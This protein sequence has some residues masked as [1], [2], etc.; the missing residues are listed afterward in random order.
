MNEAIRYVLDQAGWKAGDANIAFQPCD[1]STAQAAKWDPAKCT[2]TPAYSQNPSLVGVI[3][4]FNSGCAQLI[5]PG[6]I[7]LPARRSR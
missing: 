5:I 7:A 1:D 2:R 4:T 3:G 6:S